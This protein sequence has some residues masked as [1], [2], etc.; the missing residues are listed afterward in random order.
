[1]KIII[2]QNGNGCFTVGP[3]Q[4]INISK[5]DIDG[6]II[7]SVGIQNVSLGLYK[8]EKRATAVFNAVVDFLCD[9]T[10]QTYRLEQDK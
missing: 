9:E 6:N 10:R 1:M 7:F 5:A 2:N 8:K 4:L 3:N